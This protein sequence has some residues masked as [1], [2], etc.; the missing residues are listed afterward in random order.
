MAASGTTYGPEVLVELRPGERS[1]RAQLEDG[2]RD[3]IR[4]GRLAAGE[5]L[6]SSRA[7]ARDL[8]VSRR[9]VV[10]AY[11]QLTAEGYLEAREGSS[12][13]V[14]PGAAAAEPAR[15]ALGRIRPCYD[16]FPGAPD[17]ASFPRA[18]WAR[19]TREI[20]REAPDHALRHPEI[21]GAPELRRALAA[22]LRR[23]RGVAAEPDRI[24]IVTGATQGVALLARVL[25]RRGVRD[26]GVESP[27]FPLHRRV[28]A[29]NGLRPLDVPV[30]GGGAVVESLARSHAGAALLTPAHQMPLG[31][32]LSPA[33]RAALLDWA[34]AGHLVVEDDYDAEFRY[35]RTPVG[36]MQ[37]VA[38]AATRCWP[39]SS[40]TSRP[41]GSR[42]SPRGCTPSCALP[43]RSTPTHS[44]ARRAGTTSASI[45]LSWPASRPTRSCSDMRRFRSPRSP[46]AC[47]GRPP[48]SLTYGRDRGFFVILHRPSCRR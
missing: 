23:A 35:D 43:R 46:R 37:G 47:A 15:P 14:A 32:A 45:R 28:L 26:V 27:G 33:R 12:T 4:S 24:V 16:F 29:A 31:V 9:L 22:H 7:L 21:Q 41:R 36:A 44:S 40:A 10:E 3:A 38:P 13:T 25:R 8:G 11:A 20:L 5:R 19:A 18:A 2:L 17:V 6:P 34:R 48:R 42:A 1:L 30:D 39:P